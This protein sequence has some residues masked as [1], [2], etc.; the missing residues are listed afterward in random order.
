MCTVNKRVYTKKVWELIV[1]TS[2][3][4]IYVCVCVCVCKYI[5]MGRERERER[6]REED[7][8]LN[9]THKD[10]ELNLY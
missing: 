10:L 8:L 6:E 9:M 1:C 7:I 5:Y 3:I 4:Y 2:Y